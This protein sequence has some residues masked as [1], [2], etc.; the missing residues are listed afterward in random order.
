MTADT[1]SNPGNRLEAAKMIVCMLPDD[2]TDM[3][4]MYRLRKEKNVTRAESI[5]CG[6]VNTLQTAKTRQGKLP[7]PILGRTLTIIVSE[8][9]ADDVFE[10]VHELAG[11]GQPGN[12]AMV[13]TPLLGATVYHLPDDVPEETFK[14]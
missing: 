1:S 7:E 4:I 8:A 3:K 13:Q 5:A 14:P 12:G 2:R 6:W 11:I 9:E 10:F